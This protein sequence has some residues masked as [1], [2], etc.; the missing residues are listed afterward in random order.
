MKTFILLSHK[1]LVRVLAQTGSIGSIVRFYHGFYPESRS[2]KK[3]LSLVDFKMWDVKA[4]FI[5]IM[6]VHFLY[7]K[8]QFLSKLSCE[9]G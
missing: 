2:T 9:T 7:H 4:L 6:T 3:K 1:K 8:M 5:I